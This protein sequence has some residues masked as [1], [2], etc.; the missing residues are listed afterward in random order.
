MARRRRAEKCPSRDCSSWPA[1]ACGCSLLD[2]PAGQSL[3]RVRAIRDE[4][5][6][7]VEALISELE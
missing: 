7:R 2:D 3:D 6:R 1:I 5:R 4:I